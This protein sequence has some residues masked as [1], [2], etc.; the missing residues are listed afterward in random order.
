MNKHKTRLK[1]SYKTGDLVRLK[2]LREWGFFLV[3]EFVG[4][5]GY[6]DYCVRVISQRTGKTSR[7]I[8]W[9]LEPAGKTDD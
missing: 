4:T 5:P 8:P 7:H 6:A 3:V 1:C 9:H 2:H